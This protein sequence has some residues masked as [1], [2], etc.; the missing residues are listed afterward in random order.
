MSIHNW[1]FLK[2]KIIYIMMN[3]QSFFLQLM[4]FLI[5]PILNKVF[6][7]NFFIL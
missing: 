5:F 1:F 4:A 7:Y 6:L 3:K 2:Q